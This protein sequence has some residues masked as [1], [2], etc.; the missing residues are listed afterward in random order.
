MTIVK[1]VH[2]EKEAR[3]NAEK[4]D[5]KNRNT[6]EL[7]KRSKESSKSPGSRTSTH[8]DRKS[9]QMLAELHRLKRQM[10]EFQ[11]SIERPPV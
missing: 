2:S 8:L 9:Q 4:T 3:N 1:Y 6:Q 5:G 11:L 7:D 10:T